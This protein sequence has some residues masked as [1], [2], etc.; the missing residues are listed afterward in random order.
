MKWL[1][2]TT[3]ANAENLKRRLKRRAFQGRAIVDGPPR[4][5][6]HYAVNVLKADNIIGLYEDD[7]IE[8]EAP[9]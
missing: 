2:N 6:P 1:T 5:S 8:S 7:A 3:K 9:K 4:P